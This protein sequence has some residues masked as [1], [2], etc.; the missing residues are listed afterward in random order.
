M[1]DIKVGA[2]ALGALNRP[3]EEGASFTSFKSGT[4]FLVKVLGEE[5]LMQFY[6]Y[7][8]F[9]KVDS[10]TAENPSV[11]TPNGYP[12]ENLTPWDKAWKFHKDQS[13]EWDDAHGKASSLYRPKERYAMAFFDLEEGKEIIID[14]S[15]NQAQTLH[16]VISKYSK[17]LD[18]L[19]FELT[20]QGSGQNTTVTLSPVIDFE[21]DLTE[22][23]QKNYSEAPKEF[24]LELFKGLTKSLSEE[25]MV[26]E[27]V[28]AGFDV[29]KIGYEVPDMSETEEQDGGQG[30]VEDDDL[31][32]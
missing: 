6:S 14:V 16:Q 7:G 11:K 31:P 29:T 1:S 28:R 27:L 30:D 24:D 26:K 2:G 23:Q 12:K 3:D 13:K 10:F 5:D 32:F 18:T 8:I 25:D 22:K 17:R 15:R 20:K 21:E 19:A 9:K 4:T